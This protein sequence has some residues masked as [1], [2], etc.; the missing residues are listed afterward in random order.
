MPHAGLTISR[1]IC[2]RPNHW[3]MI[4]KLMQLHNLPFYKV[5][6]LILEIGATTLLDIP[7]GQKIE[8]FKLKGPN[9]NKGTQA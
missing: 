9:A 3:A 8:D 1:N 5:I 4:T 7:R 6:F 2:F